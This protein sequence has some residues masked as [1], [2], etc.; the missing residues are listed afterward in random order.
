MK[1][2]PSRLTILEVITEKGKRKTCRCSCTCGSEKIYSYS[3]VV[4]GNSKSCGCIKRECTIKRSTKHG[5]RWTLE[6]QRW[7]A[8]IK[9]CCNKKAHNWK[10]YGGKG[11]T[12]CEKWRNSFEEFL[13][14]VGLCP[15]VKHS[16]DRIDGTKGYE[17]GN[18]RWVTIEIQQN[19]RSNNKKINFCGVTKNLSE[20]AR[21]AH[22]NP[23]CLNSRLKYWSV[24][25]ALTTPLKAPKGIYS[26]NYELQQAI[27][28]NVMCEDKL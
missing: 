8:I 19:N 28:V 15:S 26:F 1:D 9:R 17:P 21:L 18:V 2:Y 10:W 20:W 22:L 7:Q 24:H 23:S 12:I 4:S 14:D 13:L 3:N 6:Y 16:L 25:E 11:I 5:K 27:Y